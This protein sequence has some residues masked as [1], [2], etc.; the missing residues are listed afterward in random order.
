MQ[1]VREHYVYLISKED[2]WESKYSFRNKLKEFIQDENEK[3]ETIEELEATVMERVKKW[4]DTERPYKKLLDIIW[5]IYVTR[6][7]APSGKMETSIN[8]IELSE[9]EEEKEWS[10][11]KM[12][13]LPLGK[14]FHQQSHHYFSLILFISN[15][16]IYK[17]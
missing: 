2:I 10:K 8:A 9:R 15:K 1:R 12:V 14:L 13:S 3:T 11:T 16:N 6:M 7:E 17:L 4:I 5:Q